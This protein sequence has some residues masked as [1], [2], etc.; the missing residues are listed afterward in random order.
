M[1]SG[2]TSNRHSHTAI[3]VSAIAQWSTIDK[4]RKENVAHDITLE[5]RR[6]T[7]V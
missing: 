6:N 4:L 1:N 5:S 7:A 2:I 3:V